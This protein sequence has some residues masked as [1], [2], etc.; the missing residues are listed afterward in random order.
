L[1]KLV[2]KLI[3]GFGEA[4]S[5]IYPLLSYCTPLP[6]NA[7]LP[8]GHHVDERWV[9]FPLKNGFTLSRFLHFRHWFYSLR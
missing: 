5:F 7:F 2:L 4:L 8:F 9:L 6:F 3:P 1:T